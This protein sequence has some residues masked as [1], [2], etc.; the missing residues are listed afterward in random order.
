MNQGPGA[1]GGFDPSANPAAMG[2]RFGRPPQPQEMPQYGA[3]AQQGIM[4]AQWDMIPPEYQ[5]ALQSAMGGS[6]PGMPGGPAMT[7][8]GLQAFPQGGPQPMPGGGMQAMPMPG[9]MGV[10]AGGG[11]G[12]RGPIGMPGGPGGPRTHPGVMSGGPQQWPDPMNPGGMIQGPPPMPGGGMLKPGMGDF[13]GRPMPGGMQRPGFQPDGRSGG[14]PGQGG[15]I[16]G[17]PRG[18]GRTG[19]GEGMP[20]GPEPVKPGEA[21]A[22]QPQPMQI[23]PAIQTAMADKA[24]LSQQKIQ[25]FLSNSQR[26]KNQAPAPGG[27]VLT[28]PPVGAPPIFQ[29]PQGEKPVGMPVP[30][31]Q[32]G[33][34][35]HGPGAPAVPTQT[36]P[37]NPGSPTTK[38]AAPG[39]RPKEGGSGPFMPPPQAPGG[40]GIKK[41]S[42]YGTRGKYG[43][44][45]PST[46]G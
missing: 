32:T 33:P 44:A 22:A 28:R 42:K 9:G 2:T 6:Y 40:G 14:K 13:R 24:G 10:P 45:V 26:M 39:T 23:D 8:P 19:T 35:L 30:P 27:G 36:P 18:S 34:I 46:A 25:E 5:Q 41:K 17:D 4:Q 43:P 38:P 15:P 31:T 16:F 12:P 20:S 1:P 21:P 7:A 37:F 11:M 3:E 29:L